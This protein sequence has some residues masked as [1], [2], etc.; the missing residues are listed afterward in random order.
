MVAEMK[1]EMKVN[2]KAS[3][4]AM[5]EIGRRWKLLSE[6]EKKP[7]V[8]AS[9]ESKKRYAVL[10][11]KYDATLEGQVLKAQIAEY[12]EQKK[13][14]KRMRERR[15]AQKKKAQAQ[16]VDSDSDEESDSLLFVKLGGA[17]LLH[18]FLIVFG[19]QS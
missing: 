14:K 12:N 1:T 7:W 6:E 15:R 3:A 11:E 4:V 5:K 13:I 19:D 2:G 9:D 16:C 17:E 8:K 10:K 18:R